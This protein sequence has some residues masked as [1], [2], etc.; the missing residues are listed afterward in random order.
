M[1]KIQAFCLLLI[2][3]LPMHLQA[4]KP[5]LNLLDVPVTVN[6]DGSVPTVEDVRKAVIAGC[7]VRGWTPMMESDD[8]L[9]ATINVRG[10]HYAK[11]SIAYSAQSY[12]IRYVDSDN[13]DYNERRQRIHRNY[14]KWVTLLSETIQKELGMQGLAALEALE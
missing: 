11:I 14:N 2:L 12:S 13:L 4:A 10:K 3:I 9:S 7:V 5:I 6:A 1:K 8:T